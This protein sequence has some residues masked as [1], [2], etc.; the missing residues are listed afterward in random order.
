MLLRS[1]CPLRHGRARPGHPRGSASGRSEAFRRLDDV[2]DRDKPGHDG[3]WLLPTPLGLP[4]RFSWG[5]GGFSSA[6]SEFKAIGAFFCNSQALDSGRVGDPLERQV[7]QRRSRPARAGFWQLP[8]LQLLKPNSRRYPISP[9]L[10]ELQSRC[11]RC[12]N[13]LRRHSKTVARVW[14]FR[15]KNLRKNRNRPF[16]RPARLPPRAID[17]PSG[18]SL[19]PLSREKGGA[20]RRIRASQSEN[21]APTLTPTLRG[22]RARPARSFMAAESTDGR[23]PGSVSPKRRGEGKRG[24]QS[25]TANLTNCYATRIPP[26]ISPRLGEEIVSPVRPNSRPISHPKWTRSKTQP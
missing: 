4:R 20:K 9:S 7:Q 12:R 1:H 23:S 10:P 19:L 17:W 18:S 13:L 2:D 22:D 16:P 15:K 3:V 8:R 5:T 11:G 14:F 6:S 25:C 26:P 24:F 21:R